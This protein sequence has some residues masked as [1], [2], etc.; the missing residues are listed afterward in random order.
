MAE[1]SSKALR[2][3]LLGSFTR[4]RTPPI[5]KLGAARQP[6]AA[7]LRVLSEDLRT[8]GDERKRK[9][10]PR[11][12]LGAALWNLALRYLKTNGRSGDAAGI[13][14][15]NTLV[16]DVFGWNLAQLRAMRRDDIDPLLVLAGQYSIAAYRWTPPRSNP[17]TVQAK[18]ELGVRYQ[19]EE[20]K[21]VIDPAYWA[22]HCGLFWADV[23]PTRSI[24]AARSETPAFD[25]KFTLPNLQPADSSRVT[26][27]C[28][29]S[30]DSIGFTNE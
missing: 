10:L 1:P 17:R 11:V 14:S 30:R 16:E 4:R 7:L 19:L 5:K 6:L 28:K 3:A 24:F 27:E 20:L 26:I 15:L 12:A 13:R 22:K 29:L 21:A 25:A 9:P 18:L 8:P 23:V 2:A